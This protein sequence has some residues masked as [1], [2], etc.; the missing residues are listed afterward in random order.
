M[1]RKS[2]GSALLRRFRVRFR[3]KAKRQ[4]RRSSPACRRAA[5]RRASAPLRRCG[6]LSRRS[7]PGRRKLLAPC[8]AGL[9][10][11]SRWRAHKVPPSRVNQPCSPL[12]VAQFALR[13]RSSNAQHKPLRCRRAGKLRARRLR[14]R[15]HRP[16][17]LL[18]V[19]SEARAPRPHR[20]VSWPGWHR[21]RPWTSPRTNSRAGALFSSKVGSKVGSRRVMPRS[22]ACRP[23]RR[24]SSAIATTT[25]A[26]AP[27][28]IL[29]P[30]RPRSPLS[31]K[32]QSRIGLRR[33]LRRLARSRPPVQP[34]RLV[35]TS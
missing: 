23:R 7:R 22:A 6:R 33:S 8:S 1:P 12:S 15:R 20:R 35:L 3:A 17:I 5:R 4:L 19:R 31:T 13:R 2:V 11:P 9:R 24:L 30:T 32:A 16:A 18:C 14:P 26:P 29:V 10:A 34:L 28:W 25:P 21:V 27:G